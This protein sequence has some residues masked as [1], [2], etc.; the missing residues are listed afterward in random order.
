MFPRTFIKKEPKKKRVYLL[1][2][3]KRKLKYKTQVLKCRM[4]EVE[5]LGEAE[6]MVEVI[7]TET[8][9]VPRGATM[10]VTVMATVAVAMAVA[11]AMAIAEVMGVTAIEEGRLEVKS[12][13]TLIITFLDLA[14]NNIMVL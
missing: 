9:A 11:E 5:T 3:L 14:F 7:E 4:E 10:M 8:A 13:G 1:A 2:L 6:A 12:T